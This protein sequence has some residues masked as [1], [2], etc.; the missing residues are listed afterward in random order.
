MDQ[1][2][3]V[4]V[5]VLSPVANSRSLKLLE[6]R[7][8][9][10]GQTLNSS[11]EQTLGCRLEIDICPTSLIPVSYICRQAGI[12]TLRVSAK[13][14]GACVYMFCKRV[15]RKSQTTKTLTP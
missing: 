5:V 15:A 13:Y 8:L 2:E 1:R 6:I 7:N 14:T 9:F 3:S 4:T 10:E 12:T 11:A